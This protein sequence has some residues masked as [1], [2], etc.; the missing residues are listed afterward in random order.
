M[1]RRRSSGILMHVTSLPA[2]YGVGDF[3]PEAYQFADFLQAAGQNYWQMLPL[4][5]T[6][7]RTGYSP[8]NCFSAFAGHSLLISPDLL[9]EDGLLRRAELS[10]LPAF[11]AETVDYDKATAC[12][13]PLFDAAFSRFQSR[14][15]PADYEEFLHRH[16][17]WLDPYALFV[18]LRK[19]FRNR[20][21]CDWPAALRDGKG[22][23][24]EAAR[25]DLREP[26]EREKFLQYAFYRQYL[27]LKRYCNER[28]IQVAGDIPIY[29]A[30]DSAD[31]WSHPDL[32]KLTRDKR[33]R[34]VAGVP[35]D[36]FSKTGQL[37]GNPVYNWDRL[38][39][40]RFDWWIRRLKHN[41]TLFDFVRIDHFRGFVD[42]WEVP[43][44]H[45][46]AIRGRWAQA[47]HTQFFRELFRQIPFAAIFAED[48]GFITADVR[49]VVSTYGFPRM[50][51]LQFAFDGDPARNVHMPHNYG[52][53]LIVYTGTHDNNT[54]RGWFEK[55]LTKPTRQKLFDYIGHKVPA[56]DV[57]W[58]LMRIAMA[59][60]AKIAIV[61]MQDV[62]GLGAAARMNFPAKSQGNWRWRMRSGQTTSRVA[63]R[64]RKLTVAYARA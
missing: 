59:S 22:R 29:V 35:P 2:K 5:H 64:L 18:A 8:Y 13:S 63:E 48:L 25:G 24:L 42:F 15:R 1:L 49:E 41:L 51:V 45:K 58:E 6:T 40:T 23:A 43:A 31:V 54:T 17:A 60:V 10:D 4:N 33:P 27:R 19:R 14:A 21:W 7:A 9:R 11:P 57:S 55:D 44:G 56:S 26:I 3:G 50:A 34:L 20:L 30:H 62:L 28:G 47:P 52:E 39:E 12:K 46:T 37:W 61:P 53:N 16:H 32:F 36:Y 38:E